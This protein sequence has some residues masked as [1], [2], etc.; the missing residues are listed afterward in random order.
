[1]AQ[2]LLIEIGTEEIP[3]SY[4]EPALQ[5]LQQTIHQKLNDLH[6]HHGQIKTAATPRRLCLVVS[7]LVKGQEDQRL[8][9]MG[10]P[11]QAAF[12]QDNQPTK[13]AL[14]FAASRGAKVEDLQ[15]VNT[16][17]G[18]YLMVV[19]EIK[20]QSSSDLL[21]QLLP[22]AILAIPFPKSM[23]WADQQILFARP[24]QWLLALY[25]GEVIP[26]SLA[27]INSG[28][29]TRGHRFTAPAAFAVKDFA[30]YQQQLAQ[31]DVEID[32]AHR[33]E[34]V[35]QEVSKATDEINGE[36]VFDQQ[37]LTTVTNLVE[38]PQAVCGN[39]AEK[40]LALP[41]EVLTTSMRVNQKYFTVAAKNGD[42]LPYFVAVNNTKVK[43]L[44][45][46]RQGHERVLRARL[47]DALFFYQEDLKQPLTAN[48]PALSGVIFQAGLGSMAEKSTRIALL[49]DHLAKQLAPT[50]QEDISRASQ[51]CKA[52][53]VSDM[54]GEFASL[55]G[56][57]G[58]YYALHDKESAEVA[59]A[60]ADH[61]QPLRAGSTLPHSI[62]GAIIGIADRLDTICGCF[63][64]NKRP[65]GATD[66]YG[67][68]RHAL[69][70]IHIIAARDWAIN[71]PDIVKLTLT[72]YGDKISFSDQTITAIITFIKDRYRHDKIA[73]GSTAEAV[74]AATSVYFTD[75]TDC[76]RRL[77]ALQE[78]AG[79]ETFTM[80]ASSFKRVTNIIKGHPAVSV[81][82][83]LL[84][85]PAEQNLAQ[86]LAKVSKECAPLLDNQQY[87]Q[88]LQ[89]IL[90]LKEPIDDFFNDVMVMD[91]DENV[92]NNRLSLL[93]AI[94]Q[95]FMRIGDFAEMYTLTR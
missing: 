73:S 44:S 41:P 67:L 77:A 89:T 57:M 54:V 17:K 66:P 24:I 93:A 20:G 40:F 18:E 31:A 3:A 63:A 9:V 58:K 62:E 55:Q 49:A 50:R 27:G 70:I 53:L 37:L 64:I 4:I 6:L 74:A 79:N 36:V 81:D 94:A 30:H 39:F 69:A 83:T 38:S 34:L 82:K 46:S 42:L 13:A 2:E 28:N 75:I 56:I 90:T 7:E 87:Q 72:N 32:L 85:L 95:L 52:D 91:R 8:E 65:T 51:L 1:M 35:R 33:Q 25:D 23:R 14:G 12:D 76:N 22:E 84:T 29:Q 60:I 92:K 21:R 86:Q 11:K 71:L 15:I 78:I 61:Y 68:R 19:Q 47:E 59:Q 48:I 80:L 26:F 45:L 16:P 88:A 5:H 43:K 10:P